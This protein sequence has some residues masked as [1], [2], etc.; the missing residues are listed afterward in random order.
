MPIKT[1]IPLFWGKSSHQ[2][3]ILTGWHSCRL[4]SD[5]NGFCSEVD[6]VHAAGSYRDVGS[7]PVR[8][9]VQAP[10]KLLA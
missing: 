5:W 8:Y 10:G 7:N 9:Q 2:A 6:I 1:R 4:F 3:A